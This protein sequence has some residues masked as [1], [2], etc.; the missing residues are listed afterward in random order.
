MWC[1]QVTKQTG[2]KSSQSQVQPYLCEHSE[3]FYSRDFY[4]TARTPVLY[5][6][7]TESSKD[8]CLKSS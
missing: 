3:S 4:E 1:P 7:C 6:L 2:A 8:A 5:P